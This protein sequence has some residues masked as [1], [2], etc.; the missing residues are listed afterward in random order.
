MKHVKLPLA[1]FV[2]LATLACAAPSPDH[3]RMDLVAIRAHHMD[4][5]KAFYSEAFGYSFS[6]EDVVGG[7]AC[8]LGVAGD[9]RLR[10]VPLR[11]DVDFESY[12]LLQMR[13]EVDEVEEVIAIAERHGGCQEGELH[14]RDGWRIGA[15]RDPDGNTI[16]LRSRGG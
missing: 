12:R 11:S 13:F 14:D 5:M 3:A 8:Q 2:S 1:L 9:Q 10:L 6:P 4:R 7:F 16:E 15:V